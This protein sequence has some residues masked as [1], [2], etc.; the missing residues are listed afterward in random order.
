[1]LKLSWQKLG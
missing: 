1:M